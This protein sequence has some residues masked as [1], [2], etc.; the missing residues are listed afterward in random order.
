MR[1]L[2]LLLCGCATKNIDTEGDY[3][4][5]RVQIEIPEEDLED[6]PEACALETCDPDEDS[7]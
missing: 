3:A 2:L 4:F 6:L 7:P 1:V 5:D